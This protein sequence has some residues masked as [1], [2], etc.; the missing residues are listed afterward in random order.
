MNHLEKLKTISSI[1]QY[2]SSMCLVNSQETKEQ[3]IAF[4]YRQMET[5]WKIEKS[6]AFEPFVIEGLRATRYW[7]LNERIRI[8]KGASFESYFYNC[9]KGDQPSLIKR[10]IE[11]CPVST[12]NRLISCQERWCLIDSCNGYGIARKFWSA[13]IGALQYHIA[14]KVLKNPNETPEVPVAEPS[15]PIVTE[16]KEAAK[17]S[18]DIQYPSSMCVIGLQA[19]KD[20][21]IAFCNRQIENISHII[22]QSKAFDSQ[23]IEGLQTARAWWL[24][25]KS[26]IE[27]DLSFFNFFTE[28]QSLSIKEYMN[29]CSISNDYSERLEMCQEAWSCSSGAA[30]KFFSAEIGILQYHIENSKMPAAQALLKDEGTMNDLASFKKLF[31]SNSLVIFFGLAIFFQSLGDDNLLAGILLCIVLV[32]A[33]V[34]KSTSSSYSRSDIMK[35]IFQNDI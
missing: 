25:E 13:E 12:N 19:T 14:A 27:K 2:P 29:F 7:W 15:S 11:L 34:L 9:L 30:S 22:E 17:L 8:E 4:C 23:I 10:Y 18:S 16:E 21:K 5:I 31:I 33:F 6:N 1:I 3:K 28:D 26:C 32:T 35:L 20:Q 24:N